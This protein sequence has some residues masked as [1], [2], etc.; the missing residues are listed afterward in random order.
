MMLV[1]VIFH[2]VVVFPRDADL[3]KFSRP[4]PISFLVKPL[5]TEEMSPRRNAQENIS[6]HKNDDVAETRRRRE[7]DECVC[8]THCEYALQ[9]IVLVLKSEFP[10][11]I[12]YVC[13]HYLKRVC[14]RERE[15]LALG[16]KCWESIQDLYFTCEMIGQ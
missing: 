3:S 15:L 6:S 7:K 4:A 1:L 2:V 10:M 9:V 12:F 14:P 13:V 8:V 5:L 16:I 11:E